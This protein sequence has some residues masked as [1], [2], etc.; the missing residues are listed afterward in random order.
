[1]LNAGDL[2]PTALAICDVVL[3]RLTDA[4]RHM[5]NWDAPQLA[6]MENSCDRDLHQNRGFPFL[7][8]IPFLSSLT[9]FRKFG[10]LPIHPFPPKKGQTRIWMLRWPIG[11]EL[12]E[13]DDQ[14][15]PSEVLQLSVFFFGKLMEGVGKKSSL[16]PKTKEDPKKL[17]F[18]RDE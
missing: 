17:R 9:I 7:F 13:R 18:L 6:L 1:M 2:F 5:E 11:S 16:P 12:W 4:C 8:H 15:N 14:S 10:I 3:Q